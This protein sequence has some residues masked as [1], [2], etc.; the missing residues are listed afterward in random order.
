VRDVDQE[1]VFDAIVVDNNNDDNIY[2]DNNI[3]DNNNNNENNNDAKFILNIQNE[4]ENDEGDN[5]VRT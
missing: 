3:H 4:V 1:D 5:D 2:I